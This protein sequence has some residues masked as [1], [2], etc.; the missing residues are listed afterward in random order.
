MADEKTCEVPISERYALSVREA[1]VYFGIGQTRLRGIISLD[2]GADY[3]LTVGNRTLIKRKKF[4]K[5][6]DESTCI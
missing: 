3:L 2:P 4:E 1:S 5:Y 6:I